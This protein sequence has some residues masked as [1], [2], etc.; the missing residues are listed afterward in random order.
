MVV[1]GVGEH[2]GEHKG[3]LETPLT[4]IPAELSSCLNIFPYPIFFLSQQNVVSLSEISLVGITLNVDYFTCIFVARCPKLSGEKVYQIVSWYSYRFSLLQ[5]CFFWPLSTKYDYLFRVYRD[6]YCC[7]AYKLISFND[8]DVIW[9]SV[10]SFISYQ[11]R[12]KRYKRLHLS[13]I[14]IFSCFIFINFII[15]CY[16][17]STC[18]S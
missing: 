17:P 2:P 5:I 1:F 10:L 6:I 18:S 8:Y 7:W 12:Q 14:K 4:V 3:T 13:I 9:L 11:H 15:W 16:S